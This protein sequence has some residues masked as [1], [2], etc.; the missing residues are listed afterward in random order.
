MKQH[1]QVEVF[2]KDTIED[3][4]RALIANA[5]ASCMFKGVELTVERRVKVSD[6]VR[7]F[8]EFRL[9]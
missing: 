1:T 2:E 6:I 9:R 4:A 3:V 5:P 8:N 7:K